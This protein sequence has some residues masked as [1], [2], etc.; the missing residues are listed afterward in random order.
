MGLFFRLEAVVEPWVDGLWKPIEKILSSSSSLSSKMNP[1]TLQEREG[2]PKAPVVEKYSVDVEALIERL[3]GTT[4]AIAN[5]DENRNPLVSSEKSYPEKVN[6]GSSSEPLLKIQFGT[7]V[8]IILFIQP[9][10]A[11]ISYIQWVYQFEI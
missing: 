5:H 4:I 1:A 6:T 8:F 3:S 9:V 2:S 7:E 10:L 11:V